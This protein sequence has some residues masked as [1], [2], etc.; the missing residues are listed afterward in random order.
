M[1]GYSIFDWCK[2]IENASEIH[3]IETSLNYVLESKEM[4][5]KITRNLNL[6]SRHYNFSEVEYLF[7]LPWNYITY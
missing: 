7:K 4:R 5:D 3:M 2:V 6:Y 1:D